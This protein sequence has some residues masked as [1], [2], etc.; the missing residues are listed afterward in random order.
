MMRNER[1]ERVMVFV[2]L[3]NV[4]NGQCDT[5]GSY[6]EIDFREMVHH[7][8][9]NRILAGA[10]IFDSE[11]GERSSKLHYAIR[12]CGFR[13]IIRDSYDTEHNAQKE[14]DVAMACEILSHGIKN[15]YDTAIIVSSDRDFRPVIE[16]IQSEGK[17]AEVAAFSGCTSSLMKISGDIFHPLDAIPMIR[18]DTL[19]IDVEEPVDVDMDIPEEVAVNG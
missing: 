10:Y 13:A 7:L 1:T 14:I 12:T 9:G 3:R 6:Y 15:H 18:L 5:T 8:L 19:Q 2:D 16:M 11:G 17:K 4:I